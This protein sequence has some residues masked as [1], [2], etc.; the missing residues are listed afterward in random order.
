MKIV[1]NFSGPQKKKDLGISK[2]A[3]KCILIIFQPQLYSFK[4]VRYI[5]IKMYLQKSTLQLEIFKT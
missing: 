1:F 4:I 2:R 5:Y 3:R